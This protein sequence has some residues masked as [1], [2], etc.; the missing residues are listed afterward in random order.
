MKTTCLWIF[1]LKYILKLV[2]QTTFASKLSIWATDCEDGVVSDSL[3]Q[4]ITFQSTIITTDQLCYRI[5]FLSRGSGN[6]WCPQVVPKGYTSWVSHS[7][8]LFMLYL[9]RLS[10]KIFY[11]FFCFHVGVKKRQKYSLPSVYILVYILFKPKYLVIFGRWFTIPE[12][13][14]NIALNS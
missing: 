10:C 7:I 8:L 3:M 2:F 12:R 11:P 14:R 9:F 1:V 6:I 5:V 4:N 13:L